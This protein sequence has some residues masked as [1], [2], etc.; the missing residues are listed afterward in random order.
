M[1][2]IHERLDNFLGIHGEF[3]LVVIWRQEKQELKMLHATA[4][5]SREVIQS[6][7]GLICFMRHKVL[8]SNSN[9]EGM[10][11]SISE[12]CGWRCF[13]RRRAACQ[14]PTRRT[15]LVRPYI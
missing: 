1:R 6:S 14:E 4:G 11:G 13:L 15:T 8:K 9:S 7:R 2:K 3:S 5:R 10:F 12:A